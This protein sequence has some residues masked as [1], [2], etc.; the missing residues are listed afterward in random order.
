MKQAAVTTQGCGDR[1]KEPVA[2]T[3]HICKI[4]IRNGNKLKSAAGYQ[5]DD[6]A[7]K[8]IINSLRLEYS[9]AIVVILQFDNQSK[10]LK[11]IGFYP[12]IECIGDIYWQIGRAC[13]ADTTGKSSIRISLYGDQLRKIAA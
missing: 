7:V 1:V 12:Y 2:A 5:G 13:I 9:V 6:I 8:H 11:R 10:R 3:V 4:A